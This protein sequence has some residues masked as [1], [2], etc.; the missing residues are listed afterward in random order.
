VIRTRS[1]CYAYAGG[2]DLSFRDLWS[3]PLAALLNLLLLAL[4][5][6]A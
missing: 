3:R 4:G 2:P 1:L 5:L 6:A